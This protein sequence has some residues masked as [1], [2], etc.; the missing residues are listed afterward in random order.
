MSVGVHESR[1]HDLPLAVDLE[2][3]LSVPLDPGIPQRIFCL[4]D[5]DNLSRS[6]QYRAIFDDSQFA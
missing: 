3:F 1:K 4:A 2:D 5:G 6:A